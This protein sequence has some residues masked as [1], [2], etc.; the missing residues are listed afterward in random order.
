LD[1]ACG[2]DT[3][4]RAKLESLLRSHGAAGNFLL[5][6]AVGVPDCNSAETLEVSSEPG[7]EEG[8]DSEEETLTFLTPSNR[9]DS[10]GRIGHYEVLEVLGRG[11]FGIVLRAFDESLHRVVAV[12]ILAPEMAATSPARKRF[13][14]EARSSAQIRHENVVQVHAVE[15]ESLPYLVMNFIPG[16]TLQQRLDRTGPLETQEVLE[17]GRQIAEGLAAAHDKGLI[18][19]DV[20]PGNIL[21]EIGTEPRVKITDFGLARAVDDA[22]ATQS[23]VVAGTPMFMSPEQAHGERID[24]RSDLFSL[25]SVLYTMCSGRPPFRA[26]STVGVLKRVAEDTP[27]P[28]PEIIPEVPIWLCEIIARLH[29]KK[30]EDRYQSA[31]E[32]ADLLARHL[33]QL[34]RTGTVATEAALAPRSGETSPAPVP[35]PRR[36]RLWAAAALALAGLAGLGFAEASGVTDLHD[37]VIRLFFPKGTL[38]VEVDDPGVRVSVDGEDLVISG[39]GVQEIRLKSGQHT[40]R[41][42]KDGK[43]VQ[44][45]LI[46]VSTR[47]RRVVRVSREGQVVDDVAESVAGKGPSRALAPF[48]SREAKDRQ[49]TWADFLGVDVVTTNRIGMKL[50]VIPP[51]KFLMGGEKTEPDWLPHESPRHEVEI[52][53]P[54]LIGVYEVT[55]GQFKAFVRGTDYVTEAEKLGGALQWV[56]AEGLHRRDPA[57]RWKTPGYEQ[58]DDHPIVCVSWNDAQAFCKWLSVHE[59]MAYMLPTEAQWEYACRAGTLTTFYFGNKDGELGAHSWG[60][61]NSETKARVVGQ[62]QSNA[63]GLFDLYGNAWEWNADFFNAHSYE[64]SP[65]VDPLGPDAGPHV[66]RGGSRVDGVNLL[67]S[68]ARGFLDHDVC[69]NVVGFRVIAKPAVPRHSSANSTPI[70]DSVKPVGSALRTSS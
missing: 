1:A 33:A 60:S 46:T 36:A 50:A 55:V 40:I 16:E 61:F 39:A 15:S 57:I 21:L 32:V 70:L 41:A 22:S 49:R 66:I 3:P 25:G 24:H 2:R 45:E 35:T 31:R 29:A 20:K 14:R 17:I 10:L 52:S 44:Q 11:G 37:T 67:R 54:F 58:T 5:R 18:H 47:G 56:P 7:T 9:P 51:G 12:K 26:N 34:R 30:P 23:G 6:P 65:R 43:V 8:A 19:R 27:R 48:D 64:V 62:K 28:I 68:A 53:N 59:G 4:L 63:W 69:N 42:V 13:L 38:V